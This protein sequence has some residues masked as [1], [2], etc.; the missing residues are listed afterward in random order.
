ML[1][2]GY[3]QRQY[4]KRRFIR[5]F[6]FIQID[7]EVQFE[8]SQCNAVLRASTEWAIKILELYTKTPY[9]Y[10]KTNRI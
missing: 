6:W 4:W 9:I 7:N 3:K 10:I 8:L 5:V 2:L 1:I